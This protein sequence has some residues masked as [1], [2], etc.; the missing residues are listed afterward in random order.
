MKNAFVDPET[1][2]LTAWGF[3]E[4]NRPGEIIVPV[5][6]NFEL[7]LGKWLWAGTDWEPYPSALGA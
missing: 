5:A 1:N 2:V 3:I 7:A 4:I 6:E